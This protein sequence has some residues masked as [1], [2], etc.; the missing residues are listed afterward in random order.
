M[1]KENETTNNSKPMAYDTL[2]CGVTIEWKRENAGGLKYQ[3]Y[4][5]CGLLVKWKITYKDG[6][7][8]KITTKHVCGRHYHHAKK[9]CEKMKKKFD[10]D[11]NFVAEAIN[12]T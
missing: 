9:A 12:A 5:K 3:G 8:G 7:R 11:C 2:L 10:Y 1:S 6:A 4:D